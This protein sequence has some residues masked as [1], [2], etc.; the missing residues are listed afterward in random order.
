MTHEKA[1]SLR[2]TIRSASAEDEPDVTALWRAC[3]LVASYN[4]PSKF[5]GD[6]ALPAN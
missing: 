6:T 1:A 4:D 2:L 3:D 5:G